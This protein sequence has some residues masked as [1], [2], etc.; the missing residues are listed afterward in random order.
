ALATVL[1]S[2]RGDA[3][4]SIEAV[5]MRT[6]TVQSSKM[7]NMGDV[8][9]PGLLIAVPQLLD[10]N[11]HRSVVFL[12]EHNPEGALGVVINRPSNLRL[13]E[14]FTK[15]GMAYG[16]DAHARVLV[17]GPVH[18]ESGMVIHAEGNEAGDSHA[19]TGSIFICRSPSSLGRLFE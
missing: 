15:L 5:G 2:P 10:P 1:R 9:A 18:P 17:G 4:S 14:L 16:G 7:I 13:R 6:L 11:F 12:L 19:L 3:S 8:L